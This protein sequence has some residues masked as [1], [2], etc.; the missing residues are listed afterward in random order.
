MAQTSPLLELQKPTALSACPGQAMEGAVNVSVYSQGAF[1]PHQ[2]LQDLPCF[3]IAGPYLY[4]IVQMSKPILTE[5][6]DYK[7]GSV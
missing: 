1:S 5:G 3:S 7:M 6:L 2:M 4:P